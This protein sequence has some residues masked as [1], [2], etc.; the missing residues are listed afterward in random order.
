MSKFS[1]AAKR[2]GGFMKRNAFYLLIILCIASV[3][4]VIALAVTRNNGTNPDSGLNVDNNPVINPEPDDNKKPD[5]SDNPSIQPPVQKLTFIAPCN[6][7]VLN[8]Y[9]LLASK[10]P[11]LGGQY[12]TH[13]AIDYVSDDH[14]VFASADGKVKDVGY[15]KLYGNYIVL[16]HE[17]GYMTKYM[18]LETLPTAK[19]GDTIKQGQSLGKMAATQ[20]TEVHKGAHL[21]FEVYKEGKLINPLEVMVLDEK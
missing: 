18:S 8:E 16:E 9:T 13:A 17:D 21:H 10:N 5:E 12:E 1:V 2:F 20:G 14:N 3:A 15:N 4:T 6:G 7:T 11:S 19:V